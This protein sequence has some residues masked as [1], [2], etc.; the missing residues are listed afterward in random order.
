MARAAASDSLT[1]AQ[2][3]KG[4]FQPMIASPPQKRAQKVAHDLPKVVS[5]VEL[6]ANS[7]ISNQNTDE[8]S[9]YPK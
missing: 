5:V 3:R 8:S 7:M 1:P 9:A 2:Q 6:P 4:T